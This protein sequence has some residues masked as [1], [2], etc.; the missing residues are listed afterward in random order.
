MKR[1]LGLNLYIVYIIYPIFIYAGGNSLYI[2]IYNIFKG[3]YRGRGQATPDYRCLNLY[4]F[5]SRTKKDCKSTLFISLIL[6][7]LLQAGFH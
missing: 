7:S 3:V 5:K 2:Y 1:G 4:T 6:I